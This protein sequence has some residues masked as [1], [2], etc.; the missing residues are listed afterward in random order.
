[1]FSIKDIQTKV[2]KAL[3]IGIKHPSMDKSEAENL[4]EELHELVETLEIPVVGKNI[5]HLRERHAKMLLGKGKA[6]EIADLAKELE[7]DVIV[8]DEDLTPAQQ[9]NWEA[10]T[11]LCVIDRHEVILDI[12]ASRAHTR[13][14][15]LQVGLA[16]MEYS[17]PRLK[18]AWTHLSRQRGGGTG[19][20]GQG[21][22]QLE[23]DR[24]M[25]NSRIVQLKQKLKEVIQQRDTQRQKRL[26]K[27]VPTAAIIGYTNAGKSS[28]LNTLTG[29]GVLAED[30]L[31]ATLDPTTRQ[32]TLPNGQI[33][34]LTDTVGFVRKLPHSLI[35]A[36]KA[37]LEEVVVADFLIHIMDIT[38]PDIEK[39]AATTLRVMGEL[40]AAEKR[41][42]TVFNKIDCSPD[43]DFLNSLSL[44]HPDALLVSAKTGEGLDELSKEMASILDEITHPVELLIPYDRYDIISKLH[45]IGG[46][47]S[48]ETT[49][50]G[51]YIK[52]AFPPNLS[53]LIAP[54]HAETPKGA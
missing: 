32:L 4:L 30:K 2:T 29:S 54:F 10:A 11:K 26:R 47:R 53:G 45:T 18:R 7:A 1:M 17:L 41:M 6:A 43:P 16:R 8:F 40:G 37:T 50:E 21:E 3:L 35:E 33:L 13:E 51:I 25:V 46:I 48:E 9:R 23:S 31:F 36:F 20:R 44:V 22:T 38:S 19:A 28:L 42:I 49:D 14:A 15:I 12:F 39:H 5:V 52:G 27:P 34:L 24:R